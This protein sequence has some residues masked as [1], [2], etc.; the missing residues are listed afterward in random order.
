MIGLDRLLDRSRTGFGCDRSVTSPNRSQ[1]G[2]RRKNAVIDDIYKIHSTYNKLH[3]RMDERKRMEGTDR[4]QDDE[5]EWMR[6]GVQRRT[7]RDKG[8][9][10]SG[11]RWTR[12]EGKGTTDENGQM[13]KREW[14][15]VN[16]KKGCKDER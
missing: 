12:K 7:R 10:W 4:V 3:A 8:E 2:G 16:S 5:R 1:L 6:M 14:K 15:R 9:R 13:E 11:T